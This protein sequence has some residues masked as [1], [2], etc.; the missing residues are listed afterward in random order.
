MKIRIFDTKSIIVFFG[1]LALFTLIFIANLIVITGIPFYFFMA[2]LGGVLLFFIK[3]ENIFIINIQ[4]F[5]ILL[6]LFWLLIPVFNAGS[7]TSAFLQYYYYIISFLLFFFIRRICFNQRD[8][9]LLSKSILYGGGVTSILIIAN[10]NIIFQGDRVG[11][12]GI[13]VNYL[14]YALV[15]LLPLL[16]IYIYNRNYKTYYVFL[17]V[18]SL[19]IFLTGS[20]GALLALIVFY[21]LLSLKKKEFGIFIGLLIIT[22]STMLLGFYDSLPQYWQA[23]FDFENSTNNEV[24]WSSGR[25]ETWAIALRLLHDNFIFGIGPNNFS[26]ASGLQIG[27]HNV[28]L[29]LLVETGILGFISYFIILLSILIFVMKKDF[30]LGLIFILVEFPI[31]FTGVWESSPVLWSVLS[32]LMAYTTLFCK[33]NGYDR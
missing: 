29:S 25:D 28:F 2:I 23:R 16:Y 18:F 7:I 13:N 8:W 27:V 20:R 5:F 31:F 12:N 3:K 24:N 17:L 32:L 30:Y 10:W 22:C 9:V 4:E 33:N 19:A 1:L 11:V 6:Y 15:T 26:E 21:I 14:A